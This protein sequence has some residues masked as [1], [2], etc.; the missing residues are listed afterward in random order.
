MLG[1][2]D[3]VDNE[4]ILELLEWKH[5]YASAAENFHYTDEENATILNLPRK[6]CS[7][8]LNLFFAYLS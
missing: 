1:R 4:Q 5:P 7:C 3:Y 8:K 6:E 2:A